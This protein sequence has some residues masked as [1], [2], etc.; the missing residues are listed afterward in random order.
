MAWDPHQ[1][2]ILLPL[3]IALEG[4]P[5]AVGLEDVEFDRKPVLR[6]VTVE[7]EPVLE[8]VH[9]RSRK[10]G[11]ENELQEPLLQA[12]AREARRC[13][14]RDGRPQPL[15]PVMPHG[16]R[17]QVFHRPQV[18]QAQFFGPLQHPLQPLGADVG[19]HVEEGSC[20]GGDRDPLPQHPIV[21]SQQASLMK[22]DRRSRLS[23]NRS[24]N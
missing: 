6:P 21:G 17:Q 12:R 3:A 20:K 2:Q 16:P 8:V 23:P 19:G 24:G 1:Q 13:V 7:L 11:G 5:A 15:V 22:A 10:A 9:A 18:E 4:R 14:E